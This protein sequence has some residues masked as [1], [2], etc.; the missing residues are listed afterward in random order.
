MKY[1]KF[2]GENDCIGVPTP[3]A[4]AGVIEKQNKLLNAKKTFENLGYKLVL[5][6]NL[7]KCEKGRSAS[8]L[9]RAKEI[10]NMF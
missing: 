5:S 8:E 10:N 4:G 7:L 9:E 2:I 6:K 3:S 1:P